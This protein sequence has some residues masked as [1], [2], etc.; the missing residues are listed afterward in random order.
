MLH[1]VREVSSQVRV[2]QRHAQVFKC[3]TRDVLCFASDHHSKVTC[4]L[5]LREGSSC[6]I[7][8]MVKSLGKPVVIGSEPPVIVFTVASVMGAT[9]KGSAR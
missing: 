5:A 3:P 8:E 2:P 9:P 6:P 7:C 1:E 4:Y